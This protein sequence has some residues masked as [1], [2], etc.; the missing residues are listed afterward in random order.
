MK[1]KGE[2]RDGGTKSTQMNS[3]R[4]Q[5]SYKVHPTSFSNEWIYIE[6]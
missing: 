5:Y 2:S 4:K 6:T 3:I 1:M